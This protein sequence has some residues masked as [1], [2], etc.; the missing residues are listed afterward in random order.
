MTDDNYPC[1]TCVRWPECN[2]VDA[3]RCPLIKEEG[4]KS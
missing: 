2:G 4:S 1:A 3:E